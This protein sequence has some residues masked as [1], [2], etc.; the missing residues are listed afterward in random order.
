ME[1]G[2][3][4]N[5]LPISI[6]H[7]SASRDRFQVHFKGPF[8]PR[9]F[10]NQRT[11]L[12]RG[13]HCSDATRIRSP[14]PPTGLRPGNPQGLCSSIAPFAPKATP[15]AL[16]SL[17]DTRHPVARV[18][19]RSQLQAEDGR[20][21]A[22]KCGHLSRGGGRRLDSRFLLRVAPVGLPLTAVEGGLPK[23]VSSSQ[24]CGTSGLIDV[25]SGRIVG[26]P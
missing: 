16:H 23:A 2:P 1:T 17:R 5:C 10:S 26:L 21:V 11:R 15:T 22:G 24:A 12:F 6:S 7:G 8:L 4:P 18:S 3:L 9:F 13:R 20:F 14:R 25:R 19:D